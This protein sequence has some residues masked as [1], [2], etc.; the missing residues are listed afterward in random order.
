MVRIAIALRTL[1]L[2]ERRAVHSSVSDR[3]APSRTVPLAPSGRW[4]H[5]KEADTRRLPFDA[6]AARI[7]PRTAPHLGAVRVTVHQGESAGPK[8]STARAGAF[9]RQAVFSS[10]FDH[11]GLSALLMPWAVARPLQAKC[12]VRGGRTPPNSAAA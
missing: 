6:Q 12:P 7:P 3:C 9:A 10:V 11:A 5:G 4:A 2:S 1:R 8:S